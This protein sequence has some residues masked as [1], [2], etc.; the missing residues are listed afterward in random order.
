[1]VKWLKKI[2]QIQHRN[3]NILVYTCTMKIMCD[4]FLF[5][6]TVYYRINIKYL[7]TWCL[8]FVLRLWQVHNEIHFSKIIKQT[9][10]VEF[11]LEVSNWE[12]SRQKTTLLIKTSS[13]WQYYSLNNLNDLYAKFI[14]LRLT[15]LFFFCFSTIQYFYLLSYMIS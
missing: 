10:T 6:S 7:L 1:M 5:A 4:Q 2:H 9:V 15:D 12:D 3:A 8:V 11:V 14:Y 13:K